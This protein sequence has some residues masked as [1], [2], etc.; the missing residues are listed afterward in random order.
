MPT[1]RVM[2]DYR[3][4]TIVAA[5]HE[6]KY[7]GRIRMDR[8]VVHNTEGSDIQ[9]VIERSRK[10]IDEKIED[11]ARRAGTTPDEARLL[12][13]MRTIPRICTMASLPC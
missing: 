12:E 8:V 1:D 3:Q 13:G 10:F 4:H 5:W 6:G 11:E 7:K 9:D 2:E